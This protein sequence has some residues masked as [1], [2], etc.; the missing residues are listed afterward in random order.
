MYEFSVGIINSPSVK[1]GTAS[2]QAVQLKLTSQL[3]DDY[4][5][6]LAVKRIWMKQQQH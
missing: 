3:K 4:T 2:A 1:V 6:K 5:F